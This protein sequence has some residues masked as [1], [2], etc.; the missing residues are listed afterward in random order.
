MQNPNSGLALFLQSPMPMLILMMVIWYFLLI[1]PQQRKQT[2]LADAVAK[3]DK[4]DEVV[5]A[6]GIHGT[7]VSVQEKTLMLR[8]AD[9]VKVELEKSAVQS[10]KKSRQAS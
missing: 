7:V 8:I 2:E 10:V 5:T 9:N 4:N 3:L 1:R 6:G